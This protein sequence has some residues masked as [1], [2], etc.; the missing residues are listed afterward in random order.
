MQSY[1]RYRNQSIRLA[2]AF[3]APLLAVALFAPAARAEGGNIGFQAGWA[4][5]SDAD[6]GNGLVGGHLEI[7]ALPILGIQGQVDYRLVNT[8]AIDTP[9]GSGDLKIRS[10]P[11]TVSARI[12]LPPMGSMNLFGVAG[13][14]WY[15]LIYDYSESLHEVGLKDSHETTFGWHVGAGLDIA[16]APKVSIYG[17]GRAVFVSPDKALNQQIRDEIKDFNYDSTYLAGGISFHF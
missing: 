8:Y 5:A 16:V 15:Y 14:G 17:E 3:A 9:A 7:M 12:Y 10:V 11:V 1:L 6:K 2:A 13:G 4:K